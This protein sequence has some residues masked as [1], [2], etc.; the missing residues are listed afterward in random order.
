LIDD[1]NAIT[2][3]LSSFPSVCANVMVLACG[4]L[5]LAYLSPILAGATILMAGLGVTMFLG[6][7][8]AGN[9]SLIRGQ[10]IQGF[11]HSWGRLFLF[12]GIGLLLFVWPLL[13]PVSTATLTG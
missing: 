9:H 11:A 8:R 12:I 10:S 2:Y 7:I 4:L 13:W 3:A 6:G 1:V 5:Y